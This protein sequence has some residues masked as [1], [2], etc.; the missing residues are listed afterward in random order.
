MKKYLVVL[1]C[2]LM[3]FSLFAQGGSEKDSQGPVTLEL[4]LSD[5]TLEGG[6][7]ADAVAR[8][9]EEYKDKGIQV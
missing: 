7:M 9:N 8:F 4:L 3:S 6:A 1:L 2:L 5:D